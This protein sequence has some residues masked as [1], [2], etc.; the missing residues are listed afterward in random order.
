MSGTLKPSDVAV[1]RLND[2]GHPLA[3]TPHERRPPGWLSVD[4][5]LCHLTLLTYAVEPQRLRAHIPDLFELELVT[6]DD[7]RRAGLI[8]VVNF[9][10][11]R[12]RNARCPL[13]PMSFGQTN[14]R[15]YIRHE[16]KAAAWFFATTLG[17]LFNVIPR[18]VW[19]LPWYRARYHF[20]ARQ[21]PGST[22]YS[23][24]NSSAQC[25]ETGRFEIHATDT[26]EAIDRL[27]GFAD[28]E[29]TLNILTQPVDG[30]LQRRDG[31]LTTYS[32]WHP[33]FTPTLGRVEHIRCD[34]LQHLDLVSK[35][36][37]SQPHSLMIQ[38]SIDYTIYLPPRR[39]T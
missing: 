37:L 10:D 23:R 7:G 2:T 24:L 11:D 18:S 25:P 32:V 38:P 31:A 9:Y 14:Y 16:G 20:E 13:F 28:R 29:T 33:L 26:G 21:R 22:V 4:V 34:L 17:S 5:T 30:F 36:A 3:L 8:S 1:E 6:L 19:R 35:E 27:D 15:A 39:L 12:F